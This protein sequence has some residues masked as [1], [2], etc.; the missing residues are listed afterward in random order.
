L[1]YFTFSFPS[2][3]FDAIQ[4]MA[5]VSNG[6]IAVLLAYVNIH[7][8]ICFVVSYNHVI[9]GLKVQVQECPI[10]TMQQQFIRY[11]TIFCK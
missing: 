7:L 8:N 4:Q 6:I 10:S 3:K 2:T 11:L 5:H 1:K 9:I